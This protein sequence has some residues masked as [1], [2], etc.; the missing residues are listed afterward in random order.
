MKKF[1]PQNWND[2]LS[3]ILVFMIPGL[4]IAQGCGKITLPTEVTGALIVTWTLVIQ[5]YFRKAPEVK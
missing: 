3:L 5:F 2:I 1:L 4:W